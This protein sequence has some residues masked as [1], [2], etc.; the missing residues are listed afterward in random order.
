MQVIPET[1]L[2]FFQS[3]LQTVPE[4]L[5][6]ARPPYYKTGQQYHHKSKGACAHNHLSPKDLALTGIAVHEPTVQAEYCTEERQT[7][8]LANHLTRVLVYINRRLL[9]L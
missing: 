3:Y 4:H 2:A 9:W 7:L 1:V 5:A 6:V 8:I